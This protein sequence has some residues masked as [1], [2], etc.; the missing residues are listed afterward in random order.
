M[1]VAALILAAAAAAAPALHEP[2]EPLAAPRGLLKDSTL[3]YLEDARAHWGVPGFSV[4]VVAGP[5]YTGG[6][7]REEL[8][9]FGVANAAGTPV[10]E[11]T[12]FAI[13]SNSKHT[14]ALCVGLLIER[15]V[16]LPSG[17]K[18][19]WSTKIK[20]ILPEWRLQDT[21]ASEHADITDLLSMRTGQP[22]HDLAHVDEPAEATVA[23]LR[24]LKPSLEIR[25]AFQYNNAHYITLSLVVARLSGHEYTRFVADNIFGPL[26][27]SAASYDHAAVRKSAHA[28]DGFTHAGVNKTRCRE[29]SS[30][31]A[32]MDVSCTGEVKNIGWWIRSKATSEAGAGG[33][34]LSAADAARWLRELLSPRVL[35]QWLIEKTGTPAMVTPTG[36]AD[37]IPGWSSSGYGLA[38]VINHVRG[39]KFVWHTGGLPGQMSLVGRVPERGLGV[40]IFT[41]D[42]VFG[43]GLHM[44]AL[45]RILDD[46]LGHEEVDYEPAMFDAM[47]PATAE[48]PAP[49]RWP[50]P[51]SSWDV[52]GTYKAEGYG[53]AAFAPLDLL[54]EGRDSTHRAVV[55]ALREVEGLNL[56]S[57]VFL[58]PFN[59]VF[60][61]HLALTHFDGELWNVTALLAFHPD[62][63]EDVV[64]QNSGSG[65]AVVTPRGIG[66]FG[67]WSR[68]ARVKQPVVEGVEDAAEAWFARQ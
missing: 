11:D 16:R 33:I 18:L 43:T 14:T 20:D 10:D 36:I 44:V 54:A 62:N 53:A 29:T 46:L 5:E 27:M 38:Q 66:M 47:F 57:P 42:D 2:Q 35:P 59:K 50:E 55:T 32:H 22:S 9:G 24:H 58:A 8:R 31:P 23:N 63:G 68:S 60:A 61:S 45:A 3:R 52:A 6:G 1:L 64:A 15:G 40:A 4:A 51:P 12:L 48:W 26:N 41:N 19:D 13:A 28:S 49:P 21:Y 67:M 30:G 25:Q 56:A 7:W 65:P 34:I 17:E 37:G 39:H